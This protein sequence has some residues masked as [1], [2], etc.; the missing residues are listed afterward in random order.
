MVVACNIY[1]NFIIKAGAKVVSPFVFSLN[2]NYKIYL[3]KFAKNLVVIKICLTF[4][5]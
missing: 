3:K 4:A 1:F 5:V 2:T